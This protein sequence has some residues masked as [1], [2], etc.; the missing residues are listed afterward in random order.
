MIKEPRDKEN[1]QFVK[2]ACWLSKLPSANLS[3]DLYS[4]MNMQEAGNNEKVET[5]MI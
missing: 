5:G 3:V 2:M 1:G 4:H